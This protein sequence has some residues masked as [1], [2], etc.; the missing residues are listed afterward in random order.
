MQ[1]RGDLSRRQPHD[2]IL[3]DAC[4]RTSSSALTGRMG[5][6]MGGVRRY[7]FVSRSG[8]LFPLA[9]AGGSWRATWLLRFHCTS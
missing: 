4:T 8:V 2:M 3:C 7:D 6:G 9:L 1:G 5:M